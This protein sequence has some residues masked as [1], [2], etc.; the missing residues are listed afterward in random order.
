MSVSEFITK[1]RESKQYYR[2]LIVRAIED[3]IILFL[4]GVGIWAIC[5]TVGG[6]F[7][8]LGVG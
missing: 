6:I 5:W 4:I 3:A 8:L 2:G 1:C 7:R